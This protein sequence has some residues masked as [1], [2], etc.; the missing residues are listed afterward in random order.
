[1]A[2]LLTLDV[3][4]GSA[5]ASCALSQAWGAFHVGYT[6]IGPGGI[7]HFGRTAAVGPYGAYSV[8]RVG[9]IGYGGDSYRA[10]YGYGERYG[11]LYGGSHYAASPYYGAYGYG[12]AS[13]Y[14]G[15]YRAGVY[16]AW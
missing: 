10:G 5:S 13:L 2:R 9:G 16:R 14:G 11:G 12:G 7:Y 15:V 3:E 4:A 6:H 8:G 1:L